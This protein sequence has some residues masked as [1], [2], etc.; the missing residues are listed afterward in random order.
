MRSNM[1]WFTGGPFDG[2]Y[3]V[4]DWMIETYVT[5]VAELW[6]P[7]GQPMMLVK[8]TYKR[9]GS[10]NFIYVKGVTDGPALARASWDLP[11]SEDFDYERSG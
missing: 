4:V 11:I 5:T 10:R 8:H 3:R 6:N 2:T 9:T 1:C 7:G